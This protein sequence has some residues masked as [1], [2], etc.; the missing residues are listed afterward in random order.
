M[1]DISRLRP[2]SF[3]GRPFWV[4]GSET[5]AGHRVATTG[6]PGGAHVNESFG[7]AARKYVIE[8]YVI[9]AGYEAQAQSLI[10]A[11]ESDHAGVLILPD[12]PPARVRLTKAVRKFERE[13][14]GRAVITLEAVIEPDMIAGLTVWQLFAGLVA[15]LET[16]PA[17]AGSYLAGAISPLA[18][19]ARIVPVA[20]DALARL[21]A[22]AQQG[23]PEPTALGSQAQDTALGLAATSVAGLVADPASYGRALTEAALTIGANASPVA[24]SGLIAALGAPADADAVASPTAA[25]AAMAEAQV[26]LVALST[27]ADAVALLATEARREPRDRQ[28][29]AEARAI[30]ATVT[31]RALGRIGRQG[32]PLA[33]GLAAA[34]EIYS[35][36]VTVRSSDLAPVIVV[37]VGRSLPAQVLAHRLYGT[38]ERAAEITRRAAAPHPGFM[39]QRFTALS[40]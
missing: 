15:L 40:A 27:V 4:E 8:A 30:V 37:S 35:G 39:P 19:P 13:K 1:F 20:V 7:P 22:F 36:L 14:L 6:L 32:G 10:A 11:A 34:F 17:L 25:A 2:A 12:Q 38:P 16:L 28:E 33:E 9:G 5:E 3:N 24:L 18:V 29:D 26:A 31:S 21:G 23:Q